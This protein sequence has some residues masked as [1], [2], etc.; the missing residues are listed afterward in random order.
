MN[1]KII[2]GIVSLIVLLGCRPELEEVSTRSDYY[3]KFLGDSFDQE[4]SQVIESSEGELF[5][6]GTTTPVE[7]EKEILLIKTQSNGDELWRKTFNVTDSNCVGASLQFTLDRGLIILGT[8][9][10]KE[11]TS[12]KLLLIKTDINGVEEWRQTHVVDLTYNQA[13][14]VHTLQDGTGYLMLGYSGL[15]SSLSRQ[16]I[17]AKTTI[18]GDIMNN[19]TSWAKIKSGTGFNEARMVLEWNNSYVIV[20]SSEESPDSDREQEGVNAIA[21]LSYKNGDLGPKRT[22]GGLEDDY[23]FDIKQLPN[24]DFVLLGTSPNDDNG[25]RLD[26][27]VVNLGSDP[28]SDPIDGTYHYFGGN[29][30]D[31]GYSLCANSDNS[32]TACGKTRSIN[33]EEG[34]NILIFK[35]NEDLSE[36]WSREFGSESSDIGYSVLQASDGGVITVGTA[37]VDKNNMISLIKTTSNGELK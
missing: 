30:D 29:N 16:I 31:W 33:P 10:E 17:W 32:I 3:V 13:T 7:S 19:Q 4:G 6:I 34:E 14:Y 2:L 5:I 8:M 20:G 27:F 22:F 24:G 9:I 12:S 11:G 35:A 1:S 15:E 21:F 36:S 26:A 18:N 37:G 23:G 25:G 28:I